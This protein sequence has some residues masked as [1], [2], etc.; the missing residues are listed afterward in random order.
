MWRMNRRHYLSALGAGALGV[1]AGCAGRRSSPTGG[2]EQTTGGSPTTTTASEGPAEEFELPVPESEINRVLAKDR[3]PAI[4][5]PTFGPDWGETDFELDDDDEVIGVEREGEAR[6]YPLRILDWHEVVNDT[7]AGPLLVTFC[8]LCGSGVTGVRRVDGTET[9]FGVSGRLWK[10]DL[11]MYDELTDSLWSQILAQAIRGP[12]TGDRIELVPSTLTTWGAWREEHP[13]TRVLLPPPIS[14][15]VGE[16]NGVRDY[17]RNPYAGYSE[18]SRIGIGNNDFEDDRLH[19]KT[20]VIGVEN[21]DV[22]RAYPFPAVESAGGV[23]NDTVGGLPVV[24]AIDPGGSLVAYERTVEGETLTFEGVDDRH[25]RAGGS[26]W[27]VVSGLAIDGSFEGTQLRRANDV[28]PEF[29][30]AWA[31]FHPE[32][33]VYDG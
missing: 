2:G 32:T 20:M 18:N 3:I 23:V 22:A 8:P 6:A 31:Q 21:G 9:T 14:G 12:R 25:L 27:R 11:V 26:R 7:F 33:E 17:D 30:F 28:S 5:E 29:W 1:L 16:D 15:T 10:S 24:V 4:T 13:G 19:P